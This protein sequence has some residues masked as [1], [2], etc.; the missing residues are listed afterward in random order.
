MTCPFQKIIKWTHLIK[1]NYFMLFLLLTNGCNNSADEHI[2]YIGTYTGN[3]SNGIYAYNFNSVT[4]DLSALGLAAKTEN[5]SFIAIDPKGKFLYAVNEIDSFQNEHSGAISVFAIDKESAKLTLQQQVSS[6]GAAPAHLSLDK[7]ARYLMVANYNG[8]N[9]A[10]FPIGNDG[11]LGS[12]TAFVQHYGSGKNAERQAAP[13]AHYIQTTND[14]RFVLVADLGTDKVNIYQFDFKTGT[15]SPNNPD[16]VKLHDGA[17]P[18]HLAFSPTGKFVYVLNEL[19]STV[20]VFDYEKDSG[21]MNEKQTISTLQPNFNGENTSAEI[22]LDSKGKFLYA[23]NRG[24]NSIA[25]FSINSNNGILTNI[26]WVPSGGEIPRNFEIDPTG[27]WLFAANQNSNNIQIFQ[28]DQSSGR[29][30]KVPKSLKV[31]S[32]CLYTFFINEINQY[33]DHSQTV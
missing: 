13:H 17:G 31:Y 2:V 24:D 7:S 33:Y 28:I 32:P 4:G 1:L 11:L 6:M 12:H 8:G 29:L 19:S 3:G 10:V 21:I 20:T 26:E 15:L 25:V 5:P 9:V 27:K 30:L 14:N 22:L 18:R 23:S 16:Y